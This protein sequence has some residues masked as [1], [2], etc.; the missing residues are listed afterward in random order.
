MKL[1]QSPAIPILFALL[2]LCPHAS[3]QLT[4]QAGLGFDGLFRAGRWTPIYLTVA[5]PKALPARN[6]FIEILAPHDGAF[7]MRLRHYLAVHP[8][9]STAILYAPLTYQAGDTI[10][11]A[12]DAATGRKLAEISFDSLAPTSDRFKTTWIASTNDLDLVLGVSGQSNALSLLAGRF[13][14][15]DRPDN[16]NTY[17][18][19]QIRTGFLQPQLLPDTPIGYDALHALVLNAPNLTTLPLR[20]QQAIAAWVRA[21]GRLLFWPGPSPIPP[22]SPIASIL[23]CKIG[24]NNTIHLSL[25]DTQTLG[26]ASRVE[27]LASRELHPLPASTQTPLL[28]DKASAVFGRAGLGRVAVLS[29]DASQLLFNAQDLS[30]KPPNQRTPITPDSE[31][32]SPDRLYALRFYKPILKSLLLP[33]DSTDNS[34][35]LHS[36]ENRRVAAIGAV[37]DRLGDVPGIGRFDF[38][39]I[40]IVM[41]AM[42]IVVGPVDWIVL[43]KLGKQPWTW[44]TTFGWITLITTGA[45]YIGYVFRSGDLYYR[46]LRFLDQAD[47][48][49]VAATDVAGLYSPKNQLYEFDGPKDAWWEPANLDALTPYNRSSRT[50]TEILTAQDSRGNRPLPMPVNI[51][52]LRFLQSELGD[53]AAIP[54]AIHASLSRTQPDPNRISRLVGSITNLSPSPLSPVIIRTNAGYLILPDPLQPAQTLTIDLPLNPDNNIFKLAT[55]QYQYSMFGRNIANPYT[56]APDTNLNFMLAACDLSGDRSNRVNAILRQD[57]NAACVIALAQNVPP[58][59]KLRHHNSPPAKEQHLCVVRALVQLAQTQQP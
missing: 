9:P 12:R 46:T 43:K 51:W 53:P 55:P 20:T 14:W 35:Y 33:P 31:P 15:A 6:V 54:P 24:Q 29:F 8:E 39:Y 58:A 50:A 40:A 36:N 21:G 59:V 2:S 32:L 26:L 49:I 23:P 42:M 34:D 19:P 4:M 28:L 44:A 47:N 52:S 45:L 25:K 3:A 13:Q 38:S 37:V 30:Q 16:T 17:N 56:S 22:D 1:P 41:I 18:S 10:A 7:S 48:Q 11:V 57:P 27:T 5:D